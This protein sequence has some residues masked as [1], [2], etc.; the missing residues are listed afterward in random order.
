MIPELGHVALPRICVA[1]STSDDMHPTDIRNPKRHSFNNTHRETWYV[2]LPVSKSQFRKRARTVGTGSG[3][4]T[5]FSTSYTAIPTRPVSALPRLTLEERKS[6]VGQAFDGNMVAAT[7][8]AEV[9]TN[10]HALFWQDIMTPRTLGEMLRDLNVGCLIDLS[11][12]SGV[13]AF[14]ACLIGIKY[15]GN[16]RQREARGMG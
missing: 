11:P 10:G 3:E 13:G 12:G 8:I 6:I 16:L 2:I 1:P 4:A 9:E 14:A 5:T 15:F 7:S